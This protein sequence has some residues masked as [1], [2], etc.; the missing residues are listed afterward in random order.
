MTNNIQALILAGGVGKRM[1]PLKTNK[2]LIEF[3]GKPLIS[4]VIDDV[5]KAGIKN[6]TIITNPK[7]DS[8]LKTTV[9][10]KKSKINIS[11]LTQNQAKGMADALLTALPKIKPMP[12]LIVNA[13]DLFEEN[14]FK[15]M[16]S[17][18]Q[19]K[20]I[21]LGGLELTKYLPGGYFKLNNKKVAGLVEKPGE[22]NMPSSFF[23]PVVDYFANPQ[24]LFSYLK[25][26][27]SSRDD[28]YEVA[29]DRMI[30][31]EDVSI[32]KINSLFQQ[33]K[34]PWHLLEMMQSIFTARMEEKI[35]RQV[36]ISAQAIIKGPVYIEKGAQILEGAVVKGPC[37][38]GE[39]TIIGNN[40]LLRNSMIGRNC[41]VGYNTEIARSWVGDKNWF[42]CN[43]VGDSVIEEDCNFGSGTRLANLRLDGQEIFITD[44][45]KTKH[46]SG[47]KK[48]GAMVGR[49][50]KFGINSSVM[51]GTLIGS[52]CKVMPGSVVY[53]NLKT[54]LKEK[55]G[56]L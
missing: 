24:L 29:L 19:N 1:W 40:V 54:M 33:L 10:S 43:Y 46:A 2:N 7:N 44:R 34:Y 8:L 28:L 36:K 22:K 12:L 3:L 42:H 32:Y 51:P 45:G 21:V 5:L 37:F 55:K 27:G 9:K 30:K 17:F 31:K 47:Q 49:G 23:K 52:N 50:A 14:V 13:T 53:K 39:N 35:A 56:I 25:Q 20:R 16:V 11:F 18:S 6:L 38:I 41:V 48:L 15:D 26:V 4:Y